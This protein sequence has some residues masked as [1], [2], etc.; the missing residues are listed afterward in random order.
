MNI[1]KGVCKTTKH[2]IS[3]NSKKFDVVEKIHLEVCRIIA[4]IITGNRKHIQEVDPTI[5]NEEGG[6]EGVDGFFSDMANAVPG[7]DEAMSFAEMLKLMRTMDYSVIVF[8]TA[9]TGHTLR[10]LQ[11]PSTLEKGLA[12]IMSLNSKFG[13]VLSQM[14]RIFGVDDEFGEDAILGKLE[15]MRDIIEQVN[16]QFND[17]DM[18]TFVCACIPEFLSLYETE[19]L[20]QELT[21]HHQEAHTRAS[22]GYATALIDIGKCNNSLE[23]LEKDVRRL[24]RWLRN[25][26]IRAIMTDPFVENKEKGYVLEEILS[27]GKFNKHLVGVVNMLVEKKKLEIVGEVLMEFERIYDQL[28]GTQVVL[29][30]SEVKMERDKVW[31]LAKKVQELSGAEKVKIKVINLVDDKKRSLSFAL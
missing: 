27:K 9:P 31:G 3:R 20:F 4:N 2:S 29:V 5:E 24:S 1:E 26:H 6:S 10:L 19:R 22:S 17:P 18:T 12:K 7:I 25:E 30:S 21:R 13:G 28:C 15:A 8:D 14:T 16:R 23:N 11:F